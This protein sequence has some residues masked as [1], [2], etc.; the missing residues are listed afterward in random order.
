QLLTR[1]QPTAQ[2]ILVVDGFV[3]LDDTG[4]PGLGS[5]LH[6]ALGGNVPVIGVAKSNFA[7]LNLL[8]REVL[9]GDSARPLYITAAGL[10]LDLAADHIR[11][12]K[13]EYRMPDL[14]KKL[15]Q[16]TRTNG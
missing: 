16:L 12:M 15:D 8:K 2:D 7:A 3:V 1:I 14:L 11:Q 9:R 13:G 6:E 4:K 5:R 10:D